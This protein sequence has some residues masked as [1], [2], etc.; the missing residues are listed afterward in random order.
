MWVFHKQPLLGGKGRQGKGIGRKTGGSRKKES[1]LQKT[2]G[3]K[4]NKKIDARGNKREAGHKY[5]G[6]SGMDGKR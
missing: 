6:R 4:E 1:N 5:R 3:E 2:F